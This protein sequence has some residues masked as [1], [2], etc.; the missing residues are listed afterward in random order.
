MNTIQKC[1]KIKMQKRRLVI[2]ISGASGSIYAQL[3]LKTLDSIY[4]QF[5]N[6]SIVMS[7]N[8]KTVWQ[9]ELLNQDYLN[10]RFK[11]YDL[12]DFNAPFASGSANFDT[13]IIIPCS[14]GTL[15]KVANGLSN[16]LM[17]RTAD[18]MLKEKRKL[19]LVVRETPYNLI[20]IKNM[21]TITLSGGIICPASPSFYSNPTSIEALALT[22][23]HRALSLSN[24]HIENRFTWG[25]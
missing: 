8:A 1:I 6:I 24:I 7:N 20:H 15:A 4:T 9:T 21:E 19:I 5:E 16:D 13:M 25:Q 12:Q 10:Y 14:M 2:G 3:L 11:L 22:V 17:T 23:V 18:V